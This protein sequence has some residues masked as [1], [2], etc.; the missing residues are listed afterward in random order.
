MNN[1]N[2]LNVMEE[3]KT[4]SKLSQKQMVIHGIIT[5]VNLVLTIVSV[6]LH[7]TDNYTHNHIIMYLF[8][9]FMTAINF[10]FNLV[11]YNKLSQLGNLVNTN[12]IK[13]TLENITCIGFY[14][15][16]LN[17]C[18][19]LI[20]III[21][22]IIITDTIDQDEQAFLIVELILVICVASYN[23]VT[24]C[25]TC[26]RSHDDKELINKAVLN[27]LGDRRSNESDDV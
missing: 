1:Q 27:I 2:D 7:I 4:L 20:A 22:S 26:C 10:A 17:L 19:L 23:L 12:D 6:S 3:I 24:T 11:T 16:L 21:E 13:N 25:K 5:M 14:D 18:W 9:S 8:T 15:S